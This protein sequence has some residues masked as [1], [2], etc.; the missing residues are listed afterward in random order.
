M[1][2]VNLDELSKEELYDAAERF[3]RRYQKLKE[4]MGTDDE[5]ERV[6]LMLILAADAGWLAKVCS[7]GTRDG[8]GNCGVGPFDEEVDRLVRQIMEI[9]KRLLACRGE[10]ML[11]EG[12]LNDE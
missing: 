11:S 5:R 8:G 10:T 2:S 3:R 12:M 4:S 9:H 7:D 6:R 1:K